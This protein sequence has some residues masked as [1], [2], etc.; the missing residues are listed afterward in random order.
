MVTTLLFAVTVASLCVVLPYI[1]C[2]W[3]LCCMVYHIVSG[4]VAAWCVCGA[5]CTFCCAVCC[6]LCCPLWA[7]VTCVVLCSVSTQRYHVLC[8]VWGGSLWSVLSVWPLVGCVVLARICV[9]VEFGEFLSRLTVW[10][11]PWC[12]VVCG[13]VLCFYGSYPVVSCR[14]VWVCVGCIVFCCCLCCQ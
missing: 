14:V 11:R 7:A 8:M 4:F 6:R 1:F 2:Y 9:S 13:V 10:L 5:L 3:L 12:R